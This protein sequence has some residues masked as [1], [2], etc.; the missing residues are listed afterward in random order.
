MSYKKV[1]KYIFFGEHY[2]NQ[3][4]QARS[5][6]QSEIKIGILNGY[7]FFTIGTNLTSSKSM[8]L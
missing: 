2:P 3:A 5:A 1:V 6:R 8:L 4:R 7:P